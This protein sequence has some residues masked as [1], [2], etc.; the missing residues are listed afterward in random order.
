M[1]DD[2]AVSQYLVSPQVHKEFMENYFK[3]TPNYELLG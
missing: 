1:K 3:G 2:P